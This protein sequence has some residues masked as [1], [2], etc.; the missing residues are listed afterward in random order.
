MYRNIDVLKGRPAADVH[1]EMRAWSRALGADC[2]HCHVPERWQDDSKPT[3]ATARSMF[4]MVGDLNAGALAGLD[5][6]ACWTCHRG[7]TKPPRLP[8]DRLAAER[9][10]WPSSLV[11][12]SD[13]VKLAM[14]VYSVTLGVGCEHCHA[15]G[16]WRSDGRPAFRMV[17]RMNAMFETFPKYMP[18]TAKTQCW[19]CHQ[20]SKAPARRP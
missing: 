13:R 10:R 16:D 8:Q 20:G 4:R 14:T 12:S 7:H 3:F 17:A 11:D 5:G 15:P 19:M 2:T 18:K 1:K 9:E 6:I